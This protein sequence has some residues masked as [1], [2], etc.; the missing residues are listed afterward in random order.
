MRPG[1]GVDPKFH[2]S[3]G[4]QRGSFGYLGELVEG[5]LGG[6]HVSV[7]HEPPYLSIIRNDVRL[8]AAGR[9]GTVSP[10]GRS[11]MFSQLVEANIHQFDGVHCILAVPRIHRAVCVLA[12]EGE[13]RAD[14]SVGC[15]AIARSE[16]V[17]DVQ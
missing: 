9:D 16:V 4:H 2:R 14:R 13:F 3:S 6:R 10:I 17:A 11:Q 1:C 12:V 8:D 5:F 7:A 15:Q